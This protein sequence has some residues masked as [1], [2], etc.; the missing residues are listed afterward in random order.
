MK[1]R[2]SL[3]IYHWIR[4]Q[5]I[6]D[7]F[8]SNEYAKIVNNYESKF[9]NK[10]SVCNLQF[11]G[12]GESGKSTFVK[13]MR[14]IHGDGYS[15]ADRRQ[16]KELVHRNVFMSIQQLIRAMETLQISYDDPSAEVIFSK[17]VRKNLFA[18]KY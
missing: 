5:F 16:H 1:F 9:V 13:Q 10:C 11:E 15:I 18:E 6:W 7:Q 14:I 12:T 17:F 8:R 3:R 2:V 4:N